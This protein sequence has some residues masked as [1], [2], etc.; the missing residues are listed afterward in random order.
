MTTSFL[1]NALFNLFGGIIPAIA[2]LLTVPIIVGR[3]GDV[4][5]GVFTLVTTL[6]GYFAILDINAT[7]G[8]IKYLSEH[9]ARGDHRKASEVVTF[10]AGIYFLIGILGAIGLWSFANPLI[11]HVFQVPSELHV[12]GVNALRWAAGGFFFGQLQI[13]LASI[14]QALQRY[15]ISGKIESLFGTL[16]SLSTVVA[17]L[18]G[19]G[20]IEV[21]AARV[22]LSLVNCAVLARAI[23]SLMPELRPVRPSRET[24]IGLIH[25]SAYGYLSRFASISYINADKLFI[26]ALQDMRSLSMYTVPFMLANR[27]MG[28]FFRLV[29]VVFPVTSAMAA[30]GNT[31]QL[32]K[33]YIDATRYYTFLNASI[34]ATLMLF[35]RELLHYWAGD[36]FGQDAALILCIVS[37]AVMFDSLTNL[38]SLVNDG[39]GQPRNT[40]LMALAR[41]AIGLTLGF[42]AVKYYGTIG[43][44]S[45]LMVVSALMTIVFLTYIHGRTIPFALKTVSVAYVPALALIL[46]AGFCAFILHQ[47][48][49]LSLSEFG[50][51]LLLWSVSLFSAAWFFVVR[52]EHRLALIN[53]GV[54][55]L[56]RSGKQTP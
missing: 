11:Q 37:L 54:L 50:G 10:G 7:A 30:T 22:F 13:Y 42:F 44:A 19:G 26:G 1:R 52:K 41:A 5:Y 9:N 55:L 12:E 15:D 53:R 35:S 28:L 40:G 18:L 2:S 34:V 56:G 29:H 16:V 45:S 27:V 6:V 33:L 4:Q 48:V 8:S 3:L 47:R 51:T 25:F 46:P 23:K 14:P 49:V 21:M 39:L 38:P 36:V 20:L 17:V 32:E 31:P 24:G 43:A